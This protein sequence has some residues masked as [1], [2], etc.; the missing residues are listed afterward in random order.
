M[1][2]DE[3]EFGNLKTDGIDG[4]TLHTVARII[5]KGHMWFIGARWAEA[6]LGQRTAECSSQ[7]A[8]AI[9]SIAPEQNE[10]P[11]GS[12]EGHGGIETGIDCR[13]ANRIG[14]TACRLH[15]S[16]VAVVPNQLQND[17]ETFEHDTLAG[18]AMQR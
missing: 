7:F 6:V 11:A 17:M 8:Y 12:R 2:F 18:D 5:A 10:R 15:H 4:H 3:R 13:K 14:C 16:L 1:A 9:E